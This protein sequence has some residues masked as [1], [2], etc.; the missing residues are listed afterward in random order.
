MRT[1]HPPTRTMTDSLSRAQ[2]FRSAQRNAM[3]TGVAISICAY[4]LG[5]RAKESPNKGIIKFRMDYACDMSPLERM[6]LCYHG[7]PS[8]ETHARL[9]ALTNT[10]DESILSRLRTRAETHRE[11]QRALIEVDSSFPHGGVSA[12]VPLFRRR[13]EPKN[14]TALRFYFTEWRDSLPSDAQIMWKKKVWDSHFHAWA[15][16]VH[17]LK[18]ERLQR[19]ECD[20]HT[21]EIAAKLRL[22][23]REQ[24]RRQGE[25]REAPLPVQ[26]A[27]PQERTDTPEHCP[28]CG[29][30]VRLGNNFAKFCKNPTQCGKKMFL[31]ATGKHGRKSRKKM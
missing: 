7:F 17:L 5:D 4:D 21:A 2:F 29:K 25:K 11:L 1:V 10:E 13:R 31:W 22:R 20:R 15:A 26:R 19:S 8:G 18:N 24:R 27:A 9:E 28:H 23:E 16:S 14:R 12:A 3:D 30:E 6:S